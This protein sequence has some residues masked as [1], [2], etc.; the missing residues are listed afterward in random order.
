[1]P[2]CEY[3]TIREFS[4]DRLLMKRIRIA[5][6]TWIDYR[7]ASF[8]SR[9]LAFVLDLVIRWSA[10]FFIGVILLIVIGSTTSGPLLAHVVTHLGQVA[11]AALVLLV[12]LVEIGYPVFYEV[13]RD[14]Q[15]PGKRLLGLRVVTEHGLPLTLKASVLRN[16]FNIVDAIPGAGGIAL[17]TMAINKTAQRLGD[18]VA[19]TYVIYDSEHN[20]GVTE[21]TFNQNSALVSVPQPVYTKV[22]QYLLRKDQIQPEFRDRV[23]TG[24]YNQVR[25]AVDPTLWELHAKNR[26]LEELLPLLRPLSY[27]YDSRAQQ[28]PPIMDWS[29][30][31][32][33]LK[34]ADR[35]FSKLVS[36]SSATVSLAELHDAAQAYQR[37]CQRHAFLSTFFPATV[38]SAIAAS[39]TRRGRTLL[40]GT[41]HERARYSTR[42]N[43]F[44]RVQEG[45]RACSNHCALAATL[46][47]ASAL[48]AVL[49]VFINPNL[50]WLFI[51]EELGTRVSAGYLWT[52]DVKG[53]STV[54]ASLIMTNNIRVTVTAFALGI[55][56]CVGTILL[57][58]F[59]GV[60]LGGMFAAL[61]KYGMTHKL[62]DFILAHGFLEISV[63]VVAAGSGLYLGD[64]ILN[65]GFQPR[66]VSVQERARKIIDLVIFSALC[67]VP[68]G[69][70]EGFVSPYAYPTIFKLMGGVLVGSMYWYALAGPSRRVDSGATGG[71]NLSPTASRKA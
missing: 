40:Y 58:L 47:G 62:L 27:Q 50:G 43:F 17:I 14:G 71:R 30:A 21:A 41:R 37:A 19:G 46:F 68:A 10:I 25:E 13:L 63:I 1:M 18:L 42:A 31:A 48:L 6:Q 69:L 49:A 15:T 51:S 45:F 29:G 61:S 9:F 65:P 32:Q 53:H 5:E 20:S 36:D 2:T 64:G 55:S 8:G 24:I 39:I 44:S 52:D 34:E 28:P 59:N 57:M 67:L 60:H 12:L 22:Q 3:L 26:S 35:C 33:D 66:W 23:E 4:A 38:E 16:T 7:P 54:A 70:I 11:V 56:A